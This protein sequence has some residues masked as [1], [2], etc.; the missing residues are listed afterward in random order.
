[1]KVGGFEMRLLLEAAGFRVHGATRADCVH[2]EGHSRNTV[3]F[4]GEVAFCHRCKWAANTVALARTLG[5]L[6]GNPEAV[7]AF[8]QDA[9]RRAVIDGEIRQFE[10]WRDAKIREVS[11]RYRLLSKAAVRASEVLAK[12]PNCEQ[13]W[14]ALARFYHV[15]AQLSAVF[16]W[17]MFTKAS[18]WLEKDSTPLEV[19]DTWRSHAA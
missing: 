5:L 9:K 4:T 18:V 1:M 12:F 13:A 7:S 8:R 19:F 11:D 15:E 10:A 17:L 2:C 6:R 3:A 16:D 14:D